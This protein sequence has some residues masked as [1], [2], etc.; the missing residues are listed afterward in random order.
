MK[1]A[2][3]R[4]YN[5]AIV[6]CMFHHFNSSI[7]LI[8]LQIIPIYIYIKI[9]V[10]EENTSR[11]GHESECSNSSVPKNKQLNEGRSSSSGEGE[12]KS[13]HGVYFSC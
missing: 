12:I 13:V 5:K 4:V 11:N 1:L 7:S 3:Q 10:F 6:A 8:Y 9:V 2:L